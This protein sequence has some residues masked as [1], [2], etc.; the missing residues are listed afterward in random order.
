M[1][2]EVGAALQLSLKQV[3]GMATRGELRDVG[4][5]F[6]REFDPA[7]VVAKAEALATEDSLSPLCPLVAGY[8]ADGRLEIAR[9]ATTSTRPPVPLALIEAAW[10]MHANASTCVHKDRA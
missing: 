9:P 7:E 8:I 3:A 6:R 4:T 1:P 10:P 2:H 5:S